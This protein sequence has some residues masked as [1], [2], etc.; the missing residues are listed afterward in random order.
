MAYIITVCP[1][2]DGQGNILRK[3]IR[4]NHQII[5]I[6]DECDAV[7]FNDQNIQ[8]ENFIDYSVYMETLS[9]K[10]LWSELDDA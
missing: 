6:C 4:F 2:C 8:T 10:G 7:W 9:K 5:Y 3:K 1:R